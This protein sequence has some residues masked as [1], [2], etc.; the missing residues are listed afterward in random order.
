MDLKLSKTWAVITVDFIL[1]ISVIVFYGI[2]QAN[3]WVNNYLLHHTYTI[4]KKQ[5]IWHLS[6]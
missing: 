2:V 6:C 3:A 5:R 4:N 1:P